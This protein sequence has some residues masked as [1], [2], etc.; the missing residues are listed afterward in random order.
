MIPSERQVFSVFHR[1]VVPHFQVG[2]EHTLE[3]GERQIVSYNTSSKRKRVYAR[4]DALACASGL[5]SLRPW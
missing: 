5:Y 1:S 2:G 3:Q 4:S